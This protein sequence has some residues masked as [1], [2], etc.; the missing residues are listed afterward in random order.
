MGTISGSL[1][2]GNAPADRLRRAEREWWVSALTEL[3]RGLSQSHRQLL[4]RVADELLAAARNP[5]VSVALVE[6]S[7]AR[8]MVALATGSASELRDALDQRGM[9]GHVQRRVLDLAAR[10][11]NTFA[12]VVAADGVSVSAV[13]RRWVDTHGAASA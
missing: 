4:L 8:D 13:S 11:A 5:A 9:L 12:I 2:R 6:V 10:D 7:T 3:G 1:S